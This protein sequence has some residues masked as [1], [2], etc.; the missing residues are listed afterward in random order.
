[1]IGGVLAAAYLARVAGLISNWPFAVAVL[2]VLI[3][4]P[5]AIGGPGAAGSDD[6]AVD[7]EEAM[8]HAGA[9]GH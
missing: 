2:V 3:G 4:V 7:P 9:R 6:A 1:M 8:L 5:L